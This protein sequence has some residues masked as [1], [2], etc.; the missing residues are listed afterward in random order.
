[1]TFLVATAQWVNDL[2]GVKNRTLSPFSTK[3]QEVVKMV[4]EWEARAADQ[5]GGNQ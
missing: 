3:A 4:E 1:M 5:R 2:C